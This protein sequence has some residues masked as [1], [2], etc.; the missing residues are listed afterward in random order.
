MRSRTRSARRRRWR[1][2]EAFRTL[3]TMASEQDIVGASIAGKYRIRRV[4]GG[5]SMGVVCEAEHLEIGK[6]VAIKLIDASL[7]GMTDVAMRF[8]QEARATSL[9]E[10]HHIVQVFDVGTDER[11]GL[12]LVM[13]YLTG[14]DLAKVLARETR[15]ALEAAGLYLDYSKNRIDDQT[16]KLLAAL[17]AECGLRERTAAMFRG[18]VINTTE[19]RS[20]LHV[21]LR[22]PKG[23]TLSSDQRKATRLLGPVRRRSKG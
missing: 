22:A 17:A 7:A 6:R 10:S 18:D 14:E 1:A 8:R 5:G 21:A 23:T 9:V 12:Y 4:V 15:L 16:L 3:I 2:C 11:L 13:E 20:V 19:K